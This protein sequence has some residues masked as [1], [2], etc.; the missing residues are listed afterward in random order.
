MKEIIEY[1]FQHNNDISSC[2]ALASMLRDRWEI[3]GFKIED[4]YR[5]LI[6]QKY[7]YKKD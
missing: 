5:W 6:L 1:K 3:V 4:G 7:Y 2:K